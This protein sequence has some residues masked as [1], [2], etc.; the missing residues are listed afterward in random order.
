MT[1]WRHQVPVRS[2]LSAGAIVAGARAAMGNGRSEAAVERLQALLTRRYAP[3]AALLTDSGTTALRA[4]LV[5]ALGPGVAVALPAFAC[6]DLV[7]AANGAGVPVVLYDTDPHTLAPDLSSLRVAL[8]RNV[9][10]IVIVHLYGYPVDL[11]DVNALAADAGAVVIEDAAQGAGGTLHD[12]PLGAQASLAVLS[13]GRGKGM[14]G[15][16]G[17][18]LLAHDDTGA[19]ILE[20]ARTVLAAPQRGWTSLATLAAQLVLERP[21]LYA[22]PA[23]LP[24]LHLGETVYRAPHKARAASPASC[25]VVA[26]TWTMADEEL[27]TRRANA[28]RLLAAVCGVAAKDRRFEPMRPAE[29][30]RPGYLRLPVLASAEARRSAE[31]S[32]ARRLGISPSYPKVLSEVEQLAERCLN[33]DGAF[34]GARTLTARLVT[35]PTHSR[36]GS[37]DLSRLERWIGGS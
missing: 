11:T 14:T 6:Y 2:P 22:L 25:A 3:R 9:G 37:D 18:A 12:R 17:G 8:R 26:A 10:A 20:R 31:T 4:A 32:A 36:L 21:G 15:G 5:G 28:A 30:A 16:S 35:L 23:A 13:F 27:E 29:A 19:R 1:R 7:T 34:A 33:R 24:F